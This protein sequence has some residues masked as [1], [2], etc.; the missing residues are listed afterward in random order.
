MVIKIRRNFRQFFL[1]FLSG[2]P[3]ELCSPW[4]FLQ[5]VNFPFL[6]FNILNILLS[7]E[8]FSLFSKSAVFCLSTIQFFHNIG[9]QN[10]ITTVGIHRIVQKFL[11]RFTQLEI[12]F[13]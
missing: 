6:S 9:Q 1:P 4:A 13:D 10:Q 11:G 5:E 12:I 8:L 3:F 2:K 7:F